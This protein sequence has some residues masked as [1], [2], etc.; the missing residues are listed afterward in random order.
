MPVV[1]VHGVSVRM[2]ETY[3][4][5]V[6]QRN[7]GIKELVLDKLGLRPHQVSIFNPYWG[8]HAAKLKWEGASLP[9]GEAE[10][11]D[12]MDPSSQEYR[13]KQL[14]E[15]LLSGM[16]TVL[17]DQSNKGLLAIACS[18]LSDAIDILFALAAEKVASSQDNDELVELVRQSDRLYAYAEVHPQPAWLETVDTDADFVEKLREEVDAWQ[19]PLPAE[20]LG[21]TDWWSPF[22]EGAQRLKGVTGNLIGQAL[23]PLARKPLNDAASRFIGDVFTYLKER[24]SKEEPGPIIQEIANDFDKAVA[25]IKPE[26]PYL[27]VMAHSMGGNITYDLLTHFYPDKYPVDLLVTIGSQVALFEELKLYKESDNAIPIDPR[28]QR[29]D[30]PSSIKYWLNVYDPNDVLSYVTEGVF[31][32]SKDLEYTTGAG[33]ISA[34]TSY[35]LRGSFYRRLGKKIQDLLITQP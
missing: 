23:L 33:V 2:D 30:K 1:F 17:P 29:V 32:G 25:A 31:E 24:G 7:Q 11:L 10:S 21:L 28:Q 12:L 5:N 18:S 14:L 26:D 3:D 9:S 13:D 35:F 16:D 4:T 27:I 15:E 34:H 8:K 6:D 19:A 22:R 20:S